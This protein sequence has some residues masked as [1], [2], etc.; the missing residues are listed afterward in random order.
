MFQVLESGENVRLQRNALHVVEHPTGS[1]PVRTATVVNQPSVPGV[2]TA[3]A[4]ITQIAALPLTHCKR[5]L[6]S[7]TPG[8]SCVLGSCRIFPM[9][10]KI[11]RQ[12]TLKVST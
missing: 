11:N 5:R 12:S 10:T 4:Y 6:L 2:D 8:S 7:R 1:E 3:Y 9:Q